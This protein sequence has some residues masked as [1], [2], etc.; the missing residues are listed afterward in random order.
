MNNF[1][2]AA[3]YISQIIDLNRKTDTITRQVS[4]ASSNGR[5]GRGRGGRGRI[6]ERGGRGGRGGQGRGRGRGRGGRG[7]SSPGGAGRWI[8]YDQWQS[9]SERE[10]KSI[11][12]KR[13]NYAKRKI[14][15]LASSGLSDI[16]ADNQNSGPSSAVAA[17]ILSV[18]YVPVK[19]I[20]MLL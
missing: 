7:T 11:R 8:S 17:E 9:M 5:G 19:A 12:N 14:G 3:N 6:N 20:P 18:N 4:T 15:A 1:T 13:S 10:R 2:E 16:V